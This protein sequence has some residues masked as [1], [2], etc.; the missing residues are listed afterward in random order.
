LS[1]DRDADAAVETSIRIRYNKFRQLVPLVTSKD[2]S[3]TVR[4]RLCSSCVRCTVLRG[5]ETW[6]VR[7]E[8]VVALYR[9]KMRMVT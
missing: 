4:G 8:N 9:A 3:L 7:K 5:S 1:V 6:H 2:I